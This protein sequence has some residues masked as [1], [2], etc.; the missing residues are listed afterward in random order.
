MSNLV[1]AYSG[2]FTQPHCTEV[3]IARTFE[4][5]GWDV[6]RLQENSTSLEMIERACSL[7]DL[8]LYTRTWGLPDYP[9]AIEMIRNMES[10]GVTTAS[11][12]L[13]LYLGLAREATLEGDPFWSTQFVFTP[14]GAPDSQAEF[15]RREINHHY[16]RPGVV[17]DEC[18]IGDRRADLAHDVIFVG[19]Y[20]YPHAEWP[21]RNQLVDWLAATYGRRFAR[22]GHGTTVVRNK[23]LNDLYRSAKV[24]V[25]D[26]VCLGFT[27]PYYWSDRVLRRLAVGGFSFTRS[28]RASTTSWSTGSIC[29]TTPSGT[30]TD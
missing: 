8:Y 5:L 1:M 17:K 25:G 21:Y 9:A 26:S 22:Y 24:V 13:D 4:Q 14:D 20:P 23:G 18:V 7:V 19:S 3:H 11:Y 12:H 30:S 29:A 15:E 2:N 6:V 10:R 28:S 27:H 16:I